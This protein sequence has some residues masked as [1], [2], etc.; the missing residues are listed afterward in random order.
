MF[1]NGENVSSI[2]TQIVSS[3]E[4]CSWHTS[5]DFGKNI[6]SDY[7]GYLKNNIVHDNCRI[8]YLRSLQ[9]WDKTYI[10]KWN[11]WH[12][13]KENLTTAIT[14]LKNILTNIKTKENLVSENIKYK[15]ILKDKFKYKKIHGN[16]TKVPIDEIEIEN[17]SVKIKNLE[18]QIVEAKKKLTTQNKHIY[19][20]LKLTH[21][22][23]LK[24][25][26][27][28]NFAWNNYKET[29][30]NWN[31]YKK[32]HN[33]VIEKIDNYN[34]IY[35]E[36]MA[37]LEAQEITIVKEKRTTRHKTNYYINEKGDKVYLSDT[38]EQTIIH[39]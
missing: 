17:L 35:D 16:K 34:A 18:K 20:V 30:S 26:K 31:K 10:D 6:P 9:K 32:L 24:L 3:L 25:I 13:F 7:T 27:N 12:K 22:Y 11:K 2:D 14:I 39:K 38:I 33:Q 5:Q 36:F 8:M 37:D 15:K 1:L 21:T 28:L 23:N 19:D 29:I 4:P